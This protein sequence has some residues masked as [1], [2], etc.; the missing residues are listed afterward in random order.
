MKVNFFKSKLIGISV[1]DANLRRFATLLHCRIAAAPF[2]YLGMPVGGNPR[3]SS[4]WEP[5]ISRVKKRLV[6]WKNKS[7]SFGGRICLIKSVLSSIPLY[8]LSFFK[9]PIGVIKSCH[10]IMRSFLWGESN[11]T[12]KI[13][14]VSWEN[15]CKPKEEGGLGIK[16]WGLINLALLSKWRWRY[17][18]ERD[19]LWSKVL[20]AKYN[21]NSSSKP[22]IWWQDLQ[23]HCYA[24]G[25]S[26]WFDTNIYR[27]VGEGNAAKF[28][29]EAWFNQEK[30][31]I[32]FPRLYNITIQRD[33]CIKEVGFWL[34]GIWNWD[35]KWRRDLREFEAAQFDV[36]IDY[37]RWAWKATPEGFFTVHSAY[38]LLQGP[39]S[40][41]PNDVFKQ[42]WSSRAPPNAVSFAW[43]IILDKLQTKSNLLIRH[44]LHSA[45]ETLCSLCHQFEE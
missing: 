25:I 24:E 33:C 34:N 43:R 45:E 15:L 20:S 29:S 1:E 44:V 32:K 8:F 2:R 14:W 40:L 22:S 26:D 31:L 27:T 7:L 42:L 4:F 16:D 6:A 30:L 12:N 38:C 17:L 18:K 41:D 28:W 37:L 5:V 35:L 19:S 9:A 10:C 36:L 23:K 21:Q 3:R 39:R 13:A 11:G